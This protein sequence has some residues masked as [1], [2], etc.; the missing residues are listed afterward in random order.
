M[1]VNL[2]N[3]K[4]FNNK[5]KFGLKKVNTVAFFKYKNEFIT[6]Q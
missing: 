6:L 5:T 4:M 2:K 1:D 3:F